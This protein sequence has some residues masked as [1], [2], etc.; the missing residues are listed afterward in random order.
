[1]RVCRILPVGLLTLMCA[2]ATAA[3]QTSG[4]IAVGN[5]AG[6]TAPEAAKTAYSFLPEAFVLTRLP[7]IGGLDRLITEFDL[8]AGEPVRVRREDFNRDGVPEW[9]V[10]AP[11]RQCAANGDCLH[12][13]IDGASSREIGRFYGV[14]IVLEQRKNGFPVIQALIRQD[15]EFSSLRT[16]I[17][18]ESTYQVDDEELIRES[19]R[20]RLLTTLDLRR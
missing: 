16:N 12:V 15:E 13:L 14:V 9:L 10:I 20:L 2:V 17:F 4:A 3:D 18:I 8:V 6:R 5:P 1:M 7:F 11:E 19:A